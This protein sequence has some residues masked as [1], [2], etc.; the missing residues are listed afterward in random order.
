MDQNAG[1]GV[2]SNILEAEPHQLRHPESTREAKV[3][4]CQIADAVADSRVGRVQNRLHF[5]GTEV[6]DKPCIRPLC[7]DRQNS[8]DLVQR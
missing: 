5:F 1:L 3:E 8:L 6:S 2:K 7:G 4:H